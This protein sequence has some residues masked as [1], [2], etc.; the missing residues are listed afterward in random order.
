MHQNSK[1]MTISDNSSSKRFEKNWAV[2][3]PALANCCIF[4]QPCQL[5]AFAFYP[6]ERVA[7]SER[8]NAETDQKSYFSCLMRPKQKK[9]R[10]TT[11]LQIATREKIAIEKDT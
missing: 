11:Y 1:N 5:A 3:F 9:Q 4:T 8:Q 10:L 7:E 2:L 6:A